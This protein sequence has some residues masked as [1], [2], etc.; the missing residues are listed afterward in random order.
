MPKAR[1]VYRGDSW[2]PY[3]RPVSR[4]RL[5]RTEPLENLSTRLPESTVKRLRRRAVDDEISIQELIDQ[6]VNREL[7]RRDRLR[8]RHTAKQA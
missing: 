8:S 5:Q 2:T 1:A 6:A 4:P 3:A 7:R